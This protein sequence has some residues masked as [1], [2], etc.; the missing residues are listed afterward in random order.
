VLQFLRDWLVTHI[1]QYDAGVGEFVA[2]RQ[3]A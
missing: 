2:S 3:A 1:A